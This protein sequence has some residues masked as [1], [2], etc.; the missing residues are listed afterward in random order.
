M[1]KELI[2]A[3]HELSCAEHKHTRNMI[4]VSLNAQ[5]VAAHGT[6]ACG[7]G[8]KSAMADAKVSKEELRVCRHK[9]ESLL[10]KL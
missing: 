2:I 1:M 5:M 6:A 9:V 7:D 4:D 8:Y 10:A 3:Q